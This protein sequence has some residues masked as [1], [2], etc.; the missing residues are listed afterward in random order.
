MQQQLHPAVTHPGAALH[1]PPPP[2]AVM[3][4]LSY[5]MHS[6]IPITC[7]LSGLAPSY[8][9]QRHILRCQSTLLLYSARISLPSSTSIRISPIKFQAVYLIPLSALLSLDGLLVWVST[10]HS[11][12]ALLGL[13][14]HHSMSFCTDPS[15]SALSS[16]TSHI[17]S[18]TPPALVKHSIVIRIHRI[19]S[20]IPF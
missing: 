19:I 1:P 4:P 14:W 6:S 10:P 2:P 9:I 20:Q 5:K 16:P 11:P 18:I 13:D 7:S 15:P 8:C 17:T 12:S 3:V